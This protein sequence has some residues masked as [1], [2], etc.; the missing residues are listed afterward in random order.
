[1]ARERKAEV[2]RG[3]QAAMVRKRKAE[4]GRGRQKE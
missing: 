3:R 2:E 4:V 1:M